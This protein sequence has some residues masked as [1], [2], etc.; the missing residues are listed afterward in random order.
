MRLAIRFLMMAPLV[1]AAG[2]GS[3]PVAVS[4]SSLARLSS[5][6]LSEPSPSDPVATTTSSSLTVPVSQGP[7]LHWVPTTR[8]STWVGARTT[9]D[10][11]AL[12]IW[13]NGFGEYDESEPCSA[14]YDATANETQALVLVSVV[15]ALPSN[16]DDLVCEYPGHP[17]VLEVALSEPL[18][19]R[20]VE[21]IGERRLVFDG[22]TLATV[23][24]LP[25]SYSLSHEEP[26]ATP[27][28]WVRYWR[29]STSPMFGPCVP[30]STPVLSLTQSPADIP[31]P[32]VL[33]MESVE[34]VAVGDVSGDYYVDS[35]P[36]GGAALV[37]D[38]DGYHFDL[39]S[40]LSCGDGADP[41]RDT[42]T[43]VAAGV[44]PMGQQSD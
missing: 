2:C 44:T 3:E 17:R 19:G 11:R 24:W 22:A 38:R 4:E 5:S 10:G 6:T 16:P 37:W 28:A 13:L 8:E 33:G 12:V 14:S 31:T 18:A 39:R 25:D 20:P 21:A 30:G 42:M 23:T 40:I 15:E 29:P 1:A 43:R 26:G 7:A 35:A 9:A 41:D 36:S 32:E 27:N 34:P